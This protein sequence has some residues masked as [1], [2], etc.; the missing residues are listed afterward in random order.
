VILAVLIGSIGPLV[1]GP[2]SEAYGRTQ[3]LFIGFAIFT[4]FNIPVAVAQNVE[5]IMLA[6]FLSGC[7]GAAT[8]AICAGMAVDYWNSIDLGLHAAAFSGAT[9]LGPAAGPIAGE[10]ITASY[11]GWIVLIASASSLFLRHSHQFS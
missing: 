4:I 3:P 8:I 5:T 10:F 6:R 2:L 1:W 7:F 9:F 11:L